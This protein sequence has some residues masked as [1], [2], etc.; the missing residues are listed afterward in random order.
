MANARATAASWSRRLRTFAI[1]FVCWALT[2][3]LVFGGVLA[4][5][6]W[7]LGADTAVLVVAGLAALA[8]ANGANVVAVLRRASSLGGTGREQPRP[9]AGRAGGADQCRVAAKIQD[10]ARR[11]AISN[12]ESADRLQA[13]LQRTKREPV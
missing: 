3:G 10:G 1:A 7:L 11:Y 6:R 2:P 9:P 13:L 4:G 8:A 12:R 5:A